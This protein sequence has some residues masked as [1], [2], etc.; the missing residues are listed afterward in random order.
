MA[1]NY[2]NPQCKEG[3]ISFNLNGVL[4]QS[5]KIRSSKSSINIAGTY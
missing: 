4:K 5:A 3:F 1:F 2:V